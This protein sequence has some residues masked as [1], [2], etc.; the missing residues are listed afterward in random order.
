MIKK[1]IA[2][3]KAETPILWV[4][5]QITAGSIATSLI[6]VLVS[7]TEL[8]LDISPGILTG[9]KYGIAVCAFIIGKAQ[10]KAV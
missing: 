2:L 6:A 5:V 9:I 3:F 8:G 7:N 1:W 10:F 4:R